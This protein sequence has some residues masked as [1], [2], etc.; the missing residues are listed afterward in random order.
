MKYTNNLSASYSKYVKTWLNDPFVEENFRLLNGTTADSFANI[1]M[2]ACYDKYSL[3][4]D[5]Y[6]EK[7]NSGDKPLFHSNVNQD[8]NVNNL[9]QDIIND[10]LFMLK[11]YPNNLAIARILSL[12]S[13]QKQK[14]L[15]LPSILKLMSLFISSNNLPKYLSEA[16]LSCLTVITMSFIYS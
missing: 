3:G 4:E 5:N 10:T 8:I 11:S 1:S 12:D 13:E 14:V 6:K 16:S 7:I 2:K 15:S 9:N